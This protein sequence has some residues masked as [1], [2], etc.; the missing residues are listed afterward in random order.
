MPRKQTFGEKIAAARKE[1][2]WPTQEKLAR[3]FRV[4]IKTLSGWER[5]VACPALHNVA[6]IEKL[7][8]VRP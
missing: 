4:S 7:L 1:S 5:G 2:N 8:G 3:K 6:K